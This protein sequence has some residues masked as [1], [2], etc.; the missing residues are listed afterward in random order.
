MDASVL[1]AL[2]QPDLSL[3]KRL[4][5]HIADHVDAVGDLMNH[6][7]VGASAER[8]LQYVFTLA[9]IYSVVNIPYGLT[10]HAGFF[11]G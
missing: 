10:E 1:G 4:A 2:I 7:N 8:V 9:P 3:A 6:G 5:T 11:E